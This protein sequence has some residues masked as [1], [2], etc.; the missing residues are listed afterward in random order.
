MQDSV[1]CLQW[2]R[3]MGQGIYRDKMKLREWRREASVGFEELFVSSSFSVDAEG[4]NGA[5]LAFFFITVLTIIECGCLLL[6]GEVDQKG[7]ALYNAGDPF[8]TANF[9]LAIYIMSCLDS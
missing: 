5:R 3:E 2:E 9:L 4:I 6:P 8:E 1:N 7:K